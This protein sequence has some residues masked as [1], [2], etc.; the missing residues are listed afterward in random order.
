MIG[1]L[2]GKIIEIKEDRCVVL[3]CGGV[4]YEVFIP[5]SLGREILEGDER[6]I[7]LYIKSVVKEDSFDLY[8]FSSREEKG[9]FCELMGISKL[10][11]KTALAILSHLSPPEI[12]EAVMKED[13]RRLCEVPGIGKKTAGRIIWEIKDRMRA[14]TSYGDGRFNKTSPLHS[15]VFSDALSALINL[16]YEREEV[17]PV[18]RDVLSSDSE[19]M[20]EEA[21]RAVLRKKAPSSGE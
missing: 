8:G 5:S 16:G 20:V 14:P 17:E 1:Y 18:L 11:P 4:G 6:E 7:A 10:G 9:I 12:Y 19:L 21:V 2:E 15:G 13:I 3:T